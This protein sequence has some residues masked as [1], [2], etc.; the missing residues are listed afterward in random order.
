LTTIRTY[1]HFFA[2]LLLVLHAFIAL[3]ANFW[4]HHDIANENTAC[5][6]NDQVHFESAGGIS[7]ANCAICDHAYSIFHDDLVHFE[8]LSLSVAIAKNGFYAVP[9]IDGLVCAIP[10][11]GPPA[12]A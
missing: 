4:H 3:P 2:A 11:K 6:T 7:D 5:S 12:I 1:K 10:N 8:V 9:S